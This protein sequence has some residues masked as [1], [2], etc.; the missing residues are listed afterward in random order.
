MSTTSVHQVRPELEER[1]LLV[2]ID[3]LHTHPSNPRRGDVDV[4]A[5]SLERF[6][7]MRPVIANTDGTIVAGNHTYQA[8]QRLGWT[9]I[10]ATL[11]VMTDRDE[12][13]YLIADN[14]TGDLA[15]YDDAQLLGH[16]QALSEDGN[17]DGIGYG[18]DDI[19]ALAEMLAALADEPLPDEEDEE[20]GAKLDLLDVSIAD[21]KTRLGIGAH[22]K[23]AQ[24][25][26]FCESVFTGHPVWLPAVQA[27][28]DRPVVFCPY[29]TPVLPLTGRSEEDRLVMVQPDPYLAGHVVDKW[30]SVKGDT[31]VVIVRAER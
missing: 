24:H 22:V 29:P 3:S 21:P 8:A 16:L 23:L 14:R 17:L 12:A 31:G 20:R 19:G 15:T 5:A 9:H 25:E 30:I 2:P 11:L 1:G 28:S 18:D 27:P 4:I 10:A 26:L 13:A 7:Q 6:G